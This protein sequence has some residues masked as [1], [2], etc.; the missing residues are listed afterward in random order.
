LVVEIY[1]TTNL[2]SQIIKASKVAQWQHASGQR[3]EPQFDLVEPRGVSGREVKLHPPVLL[4]NKLLDLRGFVVGI[5]VQHKVQL[6]ALA[7]AGYC[8]RWL[9]HG[10]A[11]DGL[12]LL[13]LGATWVAE[14]YLVVL[15][16]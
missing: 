7:Y 4:G 11:D 12:E 14:V 15:A 5:I 10:L 9:C 8:S 13:G 2:L 16:A 1:E 3:R 6:P